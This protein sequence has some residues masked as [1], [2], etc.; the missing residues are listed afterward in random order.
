M[1]MLGQ[2]EVELI[3]VLDKGRSVNSRAQP[4]VFLGFLPDR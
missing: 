4:A 3:H 1:D 2:G